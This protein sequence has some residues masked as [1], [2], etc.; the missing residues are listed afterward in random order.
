MKSLSKIY[1]EPLLHFLV[2]AIG[3]FVL[4]NVVSHEDENA[5]IKRI[6]VDQ[7]NL[8]KFIQYRTKSFEPVTAQQQLASFS[9]GDLKKVINEYVR[10]EALYREAKTLGLDRD[11]YVI[12]RRLIQ[13]IDYV[14]RGFAESFG[15]I[16]DEEIQ[17]Y[18]EKNKDDYYVEPRVTFTHVYFSANHHGM[19]KAKTLAEQKLM[20]LKKE[21]ATF[22][23]ATKHGERFL[24]GLNYVERSE[25][26]V[27]SHFGKNLTDTIF[28]LD[29]SES[30]WHG[31]I[32][33]DH[34]AHLIMLIQK[35]PGYMPALEEVRHR[36]TQE[37]QRTLTLERARQ[38]TQQIVNS[39][40]IDI[41]Y[42]KPGKE[43]AK[44]SN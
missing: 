12:K 41:V 32:M 38:A 2:L 25:L 7:D 4:H 39:Y 24:Y 34:G 42:K 19:V 22:K 13:K 20:E 36:V 16:S 23:D 15:D 28:S 3:L 14:A 21:K 11:D 44:V 29:A 1:K 40:E 35:Q 27:E 9:D 33:S 6:V 10:E 5:D 43:L 31:P 37:A 30:E 17:N 18:F 8:L 26:Y